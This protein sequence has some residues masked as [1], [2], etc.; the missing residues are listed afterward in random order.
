MGRLDH[1]IQSV[2]EVFKPQRSDKTEGAE[3]ENDFFSAPVLVARAPEL[4][5]PLEIQSSLNF[6]DEHAVL[7]IHNRFHRQPHFNM[8]LCFNSTVAC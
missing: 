2:D 3:I 6:D 7:P 4:K 8:Y 5:S 1:L